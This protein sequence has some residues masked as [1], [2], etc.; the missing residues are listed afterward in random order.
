MLQT[1]NGRIQ[2]P[3]RFDTGLWVVGLLLVHSRLLHAFFK[4]LFNHL[5]FFFVQLLDGLLFLL[6][7]LLLSLVAA[8]IGGGATTADDAR[9]GSGECLIDQ[10]HRSRSE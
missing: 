3:S 8:V 10:A 2:R 1:R 4:L 6:L 7:G 5:V 9:W